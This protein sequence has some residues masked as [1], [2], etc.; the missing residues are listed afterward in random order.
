MKKSESEIAFAPP[1]RAAPRR[2]AAGAGVTAVF[3]CRDGTGG[4]GKKKEKKK[5][6]KGEKRERE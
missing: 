1:R 2:G 4:S 5:K 3:V 6:K